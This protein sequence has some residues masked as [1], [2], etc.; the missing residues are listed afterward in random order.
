[1]NEDVADVP[2]GEMNYRPLHFFWILDCSSSMQGDKIAE[3]NFALREAIPSM[4]QAADGNP[5]ATLLVRVV[6][7]ATGADWHVEQ[8]VE[9]DNFTWSDVQ[10]SGVTDLGDALDLVAAQLEMPPMPERAL[11]PVLVLVSDGQPTDDWKSAL[12]RV[13]QTPWARKAVRQAIAI[14][15]DANIDVLKQFLGNAEL[16][17]IQAGNAAAL[18]RAIKWASTAAVRVASAPRGD[19]AGDLNAPPP[20]IPGVTDD[21]DD[22]W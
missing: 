16:E 11:P 15:R 6:T 5:N 12:A 14:G 21:D 19:A 18:G 20:P 10:A 17:P 9:I 1:V 7:F 22:P 4:R 8:P 2:G 13:D 3:L